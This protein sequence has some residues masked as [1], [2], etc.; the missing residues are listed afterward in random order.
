MPELPEV[1][2]I[3]RGL[4]EKIINLKIND[5]WCDTKNIIQK[6]QELKSFKKEVLGETIRDIKRRAK[7]ILIYLSNEK[8]VLIH[9]K[10]SGHLL[11]G[12]WKKK[13][14]K[15][16]AVSSKKLS[17][18][19]WNQH[20]HF[21]MFFENGYQLAL[22][23]LRKFAKVEVW[24]EKELKKDSNFQSLG[25]EPLKE[26]FTF[27]DFKKALFKRSRGKIKQILMDQKVIAGI[28]NI[29]ASEIL[30][31]SKV[32]PLKDLNDLTEKELKKIYH[33]TRKI[34]KKA[35]KFKGTSVSDYRTSDG[36]KG[37]FS[38]FLKVY[39]KEGEEC[40]NCKGEIKRIKIAGRSTYFCPEC[41]SK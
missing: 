25:P 30:W 1:E 4:K 32:N 36:S 16:Q 33:N 31:F 40:L 5:V 17:E 13:N 28:G 37:S 22:S 38:N 29:Y 21:M 10:M 3:V 19:R 23:D 35:I 2:T 14:N 9:Q 6:P 7:N 34:L 41:Q 12:Q 11:F 24:K 27:E 26:N 39:N 8:I 18:D 15:W 20:I